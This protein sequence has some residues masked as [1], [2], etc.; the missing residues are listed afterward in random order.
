M[1]Y[2]RTLGALAATTATATFV[3]PAAADP[4][5]RFQ[6]DQEGDIQVLGNTLGQDCANGVPAPVVGVIGACGSNVSDS[7]PDVFWASDVPNPGE[8]T[9]STAID[10][11]Q[12]RSTA[13]LTLPAGAQITYARLYWGATRSVAA[14]DTQVTFGRPGDTL[15]TI[16]ADV[17][18]TVP[19]APNTHYQSTADVTA[20][21]QQLGEG[22]YRINGVDSIPLS[23]I[24][25]SSPFAAWSMVVFYT[26]AGEP[27]RQLS[28]FDGLD[29]ADSG[30]GLT[31]DITGF[32]VPNT[33]IDAKLG[34][35]A[36]GSDGQ[37]GGDTL[38]FNGLDLTDGL[39]GTNNF[40]NSS[41]TFLGL[42]VSNVGDLPQ[43]TGGEESMA[44]F[45]LDVVDVTTEVAPGSTVASVNAKAGGDNNLLLGAFITSITTFQPNFDTS[46]KTATD[47]NGGALLPGDVIQY[48]I[49]VVNTGNDPSVN[50]ILEDVIPAGVTYVPNSIQILTGPNA[51]AKSDALGDDQ[52]EFDV[53]RVRVRLG[54]GADETFGGTLAIGESSMVTF[55][56][57]LDGG[58]T[59]TIS[60]QATISAEGEN[61]APVTIFTSTDDD[62][63]PTDV[64]V[65]DC[66]DDSQC[67]AP[68]PAC[69]DPPDPTLPNICVECTG[70]QHCGG[71]LPVCDLATNTCVPCASDADCTDPNFPACH[72]AGPLAGACTE[73]SASN[74]TLCGGTAPLCLDNLGF[75]GCSDVDG[76]DEC[77]GPNSGIICNGPA[78]VCVPGCAVAPGRNDC[79]ATEFCSD[80]SGGVGTCQSQPCLDD[81]DCMDPTPICDTSGVPNQCVECLDDGDC[82][83]PLICDAGNTNTCVECT[84]TDPSNCVGNPNGEECLPNGNCGCDDDTD[85]GAIDSGV[86]CDVPNEVCVLGCRGTGNGCPAGLV[87]TSMDDTI[88]Q[89]VLP[90][91]CADDNDCAPPTPLCDTNSSPTVC[92]ECLSNDDCAN[93]TP[94]CDA[95]VCVACTDDNDCTDPAAPACNTTGDLIGSCT[96][97]TGANDSLCVGDKPLCIEQLGECGC[98]DI[99]GDDECGGSN[100][101]IICNGPVGI[102]VPGC[103]T[104]PDRNDCPLDE[105]CSEQDGSIGECL[106]HCNDDSDCTNEP[107]L[108]CDT[109]EVPHVCVQCVGDDD[110]L[111]NEVCDTDTRTCVGC[112][113]DDDCPENQVCDPESQACVECTPEKIDECID[114]ENGMEC[115]EGGICGC[116]GEEDCAPEQR[117]DLSIGQCVPDDEGTGGQGGSGGASPQGGLDD[118]VL[119][120]GGCG[121]RTAG[122]PARQGAPMAALFLAM[123]AIG[124]RRRRRPSRGR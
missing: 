46:L 105:Y 71:T 28:L 107:N 18:Y 16:D 98:T 57:I 82:P 77:G 33:G 70:D 115:I 104:D 106:E 73:C 89:C 25:D 45:D 99:D 118:D 47:L 29:R 62:G 41:R 40:F 114:N 92:V 97:C 23:N 100:S 44:A 123:L 48:T 5:L 32:L 91:E 67:A 90:D 6:T 121:C 120:G 108:V 17:S 51:G 87:C 54:A 102:C 112:L 35:I 81:G 43:L 75:C 110:C 74:A 1:K 95:G 52:G 2:L 15:A 50:T 14:A 56:V 22:A 86:V 12:A 93:P 24:N 88:G 21:V 116:D 68:T 79:P 49:D 76:D 30:S 119:V 38:T 83:M 122:S 94:T 36:Y 61:G 58:A 124:A 111:D 13:V 85:C 19:L 103:S 42:P 101:G 31:V 63:G 64:V 4:V 65:D 11:T 10:V 34:V 84:P 55:Q 117:C 69:Y 53:D 20:L 37:T 8:A 7:S 113:D 80:Q 59:G 27:L 60:N 78:G 3:S 96:E 72:A 39:G 109:S 9:A 26:L 66:E